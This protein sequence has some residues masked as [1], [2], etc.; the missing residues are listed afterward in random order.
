M[1]QTQLTPARKPITKT[2][3]AG[4]LCFILG[5]I[6]MFISTALFCIYVP[7]FLAAF[8][9]SIITMTRGRIGG[10]ILLLL[11]TIAVPTLLF[12]VMLGNNLIIQ[13]EEENEA[14]SHLSLKVTDCYH[15]YNYAHVEGTVT[16][17]GDS[18]VKFVKI[19]GEIRSQ[20]GTILDTDWTYLVG[21][22]GIRPGATKSFDIMI[23]HNSQM[24]KCYADIMDE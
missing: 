4:F 21:D 24:S 15:E 16:N 8:I 20:N 10:G 11:A 6:A 19:M 22:E 2:L 14:L 18:T 13:Q 12:F 9:L 3:V 23:P 1:T 7:L 5:L 17:N